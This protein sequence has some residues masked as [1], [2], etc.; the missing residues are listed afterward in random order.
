MIRASAATVFVDLPVCMHVQVHAQSKRPGSDVLRFDTLRSKWRNLMSRP[1]V[2]GLLT[3]TL[4]LAGMLSVQGAL[5]ALALPL[6]TYLIAGYLQAA[7]KIKLEANRHLST[8]RVSP[9]SH[10]EVTVT[11][12]NHGSSLEES[13][14]RTSYRR[15]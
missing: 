2:L 8:E 15:G 11:L 10:V 12:T 7:E 3:Y 13:C 14:W 5:L 1:L 6:V 4:L 9:N